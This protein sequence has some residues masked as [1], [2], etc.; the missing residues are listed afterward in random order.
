[1]AGAGSQTEE[2]CGRYLVFGLAALFSLSVWSWG[3]STE[4]SG[5]FW[6]PEPASA[7]TMGLPRSK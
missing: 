1:V 2:Y 5:G 3:F 4:S 7:V 6:D